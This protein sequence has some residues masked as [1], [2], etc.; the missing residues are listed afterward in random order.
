MVRALDIGGNWVTGRVDASQFAGGRPIQ[1]LR[2][3]HDG[4]RAAGVIDGRVVVAGVSDHDGKVALERPMALQPPQDVR[5]TGLEWRKNDSLVAITDSNSA[6]VFD[7]SVDGF[8][9]TRYT[10]ANLGQP[11]KAVTVAPGGRVIVA[12][13]SGLWESKDP[14]DV[15]SLLQVPIGGG[16]IPF[17][18][19]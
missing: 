4:T 11:V 12:D 2:L 9:W 7:V 19:G 16:S 3:S 17:Y 10:S 18:P 15:W 13:R 6:P 1:D 14:D 5:I 8:Q